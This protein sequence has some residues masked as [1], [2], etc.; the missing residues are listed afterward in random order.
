[1]KKALLDLELGELKE[2]AARCNQPVYRARQMADWLY[3]HAAAGIDEMRNLPAPWRMQLSDEYEIG[4]SAPE[5]AFESAD[6]TRK[7]LFRTRAGH[8]IETALIP[9]DERLTLCVSTQVGC[10]RACVFCATGRQRFCANLSPADILNQYLSCPDRDRITN[11]VFMGMGEPFDNYPALCTALRLFTADYALARSPTRLTVST[12]GILPAMEAYLRDF[13]SHLA[14][15]L[16]SPFPE[17]RLSLMPVEK[18]YP[19]EAVIALLRK[20]PVRGQRRLTFEYAMI[21]GVNDGMAEARALVRLLRPLECR[22]NLIPCNEVPGP[23]LRASPREAIEA[24]QNTLKKAGLVTTIR[25]SKG[26]DISAA[27]GL[28]STAARTQE[29][30]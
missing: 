10:K 21:A 6:G 29:I 16:H 17:Q 22:V 7:F 20:Y 19:L 13:K 30:S 28:L 12:V 1:M 26:A 3:K 25:K 23:G 11:I 14:I 15:S 9:D 5:Q 24:F 18:Q 4:R 8:F 2:L 27:C